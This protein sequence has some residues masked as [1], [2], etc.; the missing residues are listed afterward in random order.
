MI[1][2]SCIIVSNYMIV[3]MI[4][5]SNL[6]IKKWICTQL[7]ELL[8]VTSSTQYQN[9]DNGINERAGD[10]EQGAIGSGKLHTFIFSC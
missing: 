4:V 5:F 2:V 8:E 10:E 7:L 9:N 6:R 1:L 3:L